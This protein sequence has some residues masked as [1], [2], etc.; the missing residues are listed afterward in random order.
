MDAILDITLGF[1]MVMAK[2]VKKLLI[3]LNLDY[4]NW[5]LNMLE[6]LYRGKMMETITKPRLLK[7]NIRHYSTNPSFNAMKN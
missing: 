3:S 5:Y 4:L 7:K 6:N 1:V 2:M